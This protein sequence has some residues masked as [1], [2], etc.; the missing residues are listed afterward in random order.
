MKKDTTTV[1]MKKDT[2]IIF[3]RKKY[4][5]HCIYENSRL[6]VFWN[7]LAVCLTFYLYTCYT[8]YTFYSFYTFYTVCTFYTFYTFHTFCTFYTFYTFYILAVSV[9]NFLP[10]GE[11]QFIKCS[12]PWQCFIADTLSRF[13]IYI[14]FKQSELTDRVWVGVESGEMNV[15]R[16]HE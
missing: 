12:Q 4:T 15:H 10:L 6:V 16:V 13:Y 2:T 5:T 1:F 9:S 8:F 14:D 11:E 3:M 7:I